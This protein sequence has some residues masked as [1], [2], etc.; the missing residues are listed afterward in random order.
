L[1]PARSTNYLWREFD[2][3]PY[4][5]LPANPVIYDIGAQDS[6]G[7]Y[8]FGP[9]PPGSRLLCIDIEDGPG[10][11][12]VADAHD[13]HMIESNTADAVM[14][15]GVLLHCRDPEQVMREFRRILKPGGILYVMTPFIT[16]HPGVPA[17]YYKFSVEGLEVT[18]GSFE[19]IQSG[20]NRGPASS[21]AYLLV[22]F[23]SIL[24]SFNSKRLFSLNEYLFSWLFF[25]VKYLDAFIAKYD[26]ARLLYSSSFFIGRKG[27]RPVDSTEALTA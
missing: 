16:P 9:P 25:W 19:K 18:C 17:V 13:L 24:F 6:R 3:N 20:F 23:S 2:V 27:D 7:H 5:L 1:P 26:S 15:V 8:S 14:C 10:V 11:D 22:T 21:M 4:E 12:V